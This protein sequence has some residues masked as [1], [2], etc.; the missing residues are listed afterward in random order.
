MHSTDHSTNSAGGRCGM[1]HDP[2][3]LSEASSVLKSLSIMRRFLVPVV[4]D[5]VVQQ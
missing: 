2:V 5:G 1:F 4:G 3:S